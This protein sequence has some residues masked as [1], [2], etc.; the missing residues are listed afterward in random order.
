MNNI[1]Y[2]SV[3]EGQRGYCKFCGEP[4]WVRW[5][6]FDKKGLCEYCSTVLCYLTFC[7]NCNKPIT[8]F[9]DLEDNFFHVNNPHWKKRV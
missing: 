5:I 6:G 9:E 1:R 7:S 2:D 8:D 4:V 3:H